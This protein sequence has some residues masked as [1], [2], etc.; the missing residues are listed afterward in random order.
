[1]NFTPGLERAHQV[2][3]ADARKVAE[4]QLTGR[5]VE[6]GPP[7]PLKWDTSPIRS[8]LPQIMMYSLR[9]RVDVTRFLTPLNER[10]VG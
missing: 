1:M 3:V 8:A 7:D 6:K 2:N 4:R 10:I 9:N 5:S